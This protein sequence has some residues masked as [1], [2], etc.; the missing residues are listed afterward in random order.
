MWNGIKNRMFSVIIPYYNKLAYIN[1]C[2]DSILHQTFTE[3]EIVLVDDG[4]TDSG[5]ELI[6]KKYWGKISIVSQKN[7]GVSAARNTG[8]LR[9]KHEYIALLDADDAWHPQYLESIHKIISNEPNAKIIGSHYSRVPDFFDKKYENPKYF[10]FDKYFK[11]AIKN[12]Y[13]TSS[14]SVIKKSFFEENAGFNTTLKK[15]EDHDVW[16][17]AI[18]SGGDAFYIADTLVYY[19]DEDTSQATRSSISLEEDLVGNINILYKDLKVAA[20]DRSFNRFISMYVYF[21]LYPYFFDV[22]NRDKAKVVLKDNSHR[23][24]LLQLAYSLPFAV[25]QKL[26]KSAICSRIIRLYLKFII[27]YTLN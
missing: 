2:I 19:S 15:G 6:S 8:I 22:E 14:S 11:E 24:F 4:S 5:I 17:R 21:N 9:A 1:R 10:K 7:Q 12:T 23:F 20:A 3:Y 26:V 13:F 25:G 18:Q 27:R 16:F